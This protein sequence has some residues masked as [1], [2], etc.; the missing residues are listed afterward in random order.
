MSESIGFIGL[1]NM[2]QPMAINVLKAG[3]NMKVYNR[4]QRKAESITEAGARSGARPAEVV[5]RGGIV[6]TMLSND[7]ALKAVTLGHDG[8]LNYLGPGGVHISMSTV[9]P[10]LAREMH[11]LH[12]KEGCSY[13]AAP[14]FGRPEAAESQQLWI[15]EAGNTAAKERIRPILEAIGQGIFDFGEDPAHANI[16][17]ISGN[18]LIAAAMESMGEVFALAE[19]SGID[20][21]QIFEML[22]QTIFSS[23]IYKNYGKKIAE[24]NFQPVGFPMRLALKDVNLVLDSS[25]QVQS[26]MPFAS[27]LHDRLLSG[28]AKGRGESDW[29]ELTRGIADD[30]GIE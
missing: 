29:A 5:E 12:E 7:E 28:I 13:V 1:G 23:P 17:K 4:D 20:R 19:K 30:A 24:K 9:S 11:E 3:Y 15:V 8:L 18:F 27:Q 22:T 14:V 10:N 16:V 6:I 21:T 26:P 2:G 25:E